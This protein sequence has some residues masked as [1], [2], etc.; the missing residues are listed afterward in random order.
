MA[1]LITKDQ[2]MQ[3]EKLIYDVLDKLD[4]SHTNSDYY[5]EI[6][7]KMS[8]NDFYHFFEKRLPLRFHSEVFKIEPKIENI[9]DAFKVLGKPLIEP[10]NMPHVYRNV[11]GVAVKSK[12]CMV[13]YLHLKRMQQIVAKKSHVALNIEKRDMKT[14]MLTGEDK[15]SKQTDRE[16]EALASFG[17]EYTMDELSRVR[18]D[19]LTAA[20]EMNNIISTKGF[21]SE[22]DFNVGKADSIAKNTLN[23]Y[24]I[25]SHIHSNI[26]DINY[27][28]PHTAANRHRQVE[29]I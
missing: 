26:I 4:P 13:I 6:F 2:R 17:L 24:L 21:V 28:T 23:V 19:S 3:C 10:I 8:D 5:R 1:D 25:G 14:G 7:S 11:D 20:A 22:K 12:D 29:R 16:F 18:A 27:M 15:G 9:T